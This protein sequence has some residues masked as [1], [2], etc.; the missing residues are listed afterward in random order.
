MSTD[1]PA[2][3][4]T[5]PN[6][7][8][9][10]TTGYTPTEV[11]RT[12]PLLPT[13][14]APGPAGQDA[15]GEATAD[16]P[17]AGPHLTRGYQ[18]DATSPDGQTGAYTPG[19]TPPPAA[20]PSGAPRVRPDRYALKR[21]HARGGMGE[22]WLA[23][24]CDVGRAVALKRMRRNGTPEEQ[25]RFLREAR[26]TGQLEHPGIVPVHELGSDENG[27]PVYVMKFVHGR[28]LTAAV[29]E[30]HESKT[31]RE[32]QLLRLLEVF[33]SLCQTVA[34]AH[35]RGVLHRDLKPDNVMLGPYGETL[36]LDWGLAKVIGQAEGGEGGVSIALSQSGESME[37]VAGSVR[38]TPGYMPPEMAGGEVEAIDQLSDVYLLGATLYQVLTGRQPRR[39]KSLPELLT[40]ARTAGPPAPRSFDPAIPRPLE[41]I[42][43]KAMAFAKADRYAG[44]AALAED[45]QRY[46]AGEPVAAYPEGWPA[47]AIRWARKHRQALG[48]A[49]VAGAVM[50]VVAICFFVVRY[51]LDKKAA[52]EQREAQSKE[53][54]RL[55]DEAHARLAEFDRKADESRFYLASTNPTAEQTPYFDPR[56]GEDAGREALAVADGLA[57]LPLSDGERDGVARQQYDLLLLLA[58]ARTQDSSED[59]ARR[60][61]E[62]VARA[63]G[64]GGRSAG[65]HRLRADCYRL[66]RDDRADEERRRAEVGE[67]P[68]T[69][70][71]H[72]LRGDRYR[73][74]AFR[75]EAKPNPD[76]LGKA[77][78]EYRAALRL[79]PDHF[80]ARFQLARCYLSRGEDAEGVEALGACIVLKRDSPWAYTVRGLALARLKRFAE[81][82]A[83]FSQALALAPDQ[84]PARLNRG[85]AA[86]QSADPE[87]EKQALADLDAVL[88][89][90]PGKRLIEAAYYRA[91]ISLRHERWDDALS[92]LDL[93]AAE[94]P[95]F[96]PGL[97]LR[98]V[99]HL[100]TKQEEK[101]LADLTVFLAAGRPLDPDG[102]EACEG[103]GRLLGQ[104]AAG[105]PQETRP[106]AL[107]LALEQFRK[108]SDR[109]AHSADFL[110]DYAVAL[111][112]VGDY[113]GAIEKFTQAL[114]LKPDDV[115]LLTQRGGMRINTGD[116][117]QVRL[118]A[119]DL[120]AAIRRD[121]THGEAHALLGYVLAETK[122]GA[123]A[124][125]EAHMASLYGGG[126][127]GVLHNVA[128]VYAALA[129]GDPARQAEHEDMA[130]DSLRRAVELWRKAG[131]S[132]P[133]ELKW[134]QDESAFGDHLRRRDEFRAVVAEAEKP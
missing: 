78:D 85:Y 70:E 54:Q 20:A 88:A 102:A 126:D 43:L 6:D 47:R 81:A 44:A 96:R 51:A 61:L 87:K 2:P 132:E 5:E 68:L 94:K 84:L 16:F 23:E 118:A 73:A 72:F 28:T 76:L 10:N 39:G 133:S 119:A 120:G 4:F 58:Q 13:P 36:V 111:A 82:E 74:D 57:G 55:Q 27:Q 45:V 41:A 90:P 98:A 69:A 92:E 122:D 67:A 7:D 105:L 107:K 35:S 114:A 37:S 127:Y 3:P 66:L 71:D 21:F 30:Y 80:W 53:A 31:G 129:V 11:A 17:P 64:L 121:A 65:L 110:A 42:C 59:G 62:L 19:G 117:R 46:L 99:L 124:L 113:P 109:G 38:G 77:L 112:A 89:A 130:I 22:V 79:N 40:E 116:P 15:S 50:A 60:A 63:E 49:F 29:K 33:V 24:D 75:A 48:R 128:T 93:V 131:K 8:S 134:I 18:H 95:D 83:D 100:R 106:A 125:R 52:A 14:G 108:A 91:L 1:G 103:R 34:Y 56:K 25:E 32:V 123:A 86:S 26:I 97:R 12:E 101:A 9:Q 115:K 104:L